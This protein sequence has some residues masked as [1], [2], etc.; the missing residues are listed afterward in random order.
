MTE[1]QFGTEYGP[2]LQRGRQC[3]PDR[4]KTPDSGTVAVLAHFPKRVTPR[5]TM[6]ATLRL[7]F[8]VGG[9]RERFHN[10]FR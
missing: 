1:K 4:K 10:Q 6:Q 7:E 2:A 3:P 5:S 9:R 8:G